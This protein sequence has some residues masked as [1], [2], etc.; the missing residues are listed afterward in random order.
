[1]ERDSVLPEPHMLSGPDQME[2]AS[3][4]AC[5]HCASQKQFLEGPTLAFPRVGGDRS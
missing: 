1:M 2:M 3:P 4:I 5:H